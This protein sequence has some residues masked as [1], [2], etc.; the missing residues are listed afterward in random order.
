MSRRVPP[1]S[2]CRTSRPGTRRSISAT[3]SGSARRISFAETTVPEPG[4]CCI[5]SGRSPMTRT[6]RTSEPADSG[7]GGNGA[8]AGGRRRRVVGASELRHERE[9]ERDRHGEERR[10]CATPSH[11]AL[12][13]L[14]PL[15]P[16]EGG[17]HTVCAVQAML[18]C[19]PFALRMK[20]ELR[21]AIGVVHAGAKESERHRAAWPRGAAA[22]AAAA[23]CPARREAARR[24]GVV[25]RCPRAV[26]V[27]ERAFASAALITL[28]AIARA[29]A[30]IAFEQ[31]DV[32]GAGLQPAPSAPLE[33]GS[34]NAIA[35][36]KPR[37]DRTRITGR[38]FAQPLARDCYTLETEYA[39]TELKELTRKEFWA[40]PAARGLGPLWAACGPIETQRTACTLTRRTPGIDSR[41]SI[42]RPS[43]RF[44]GSFTSKVTSSRRL[45]SRRRS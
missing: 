39:E 10:Q 36:A 27:A 24:S 41:H 33:M 22:R 21:L 5:E 26:A 19:G 16:S 9:A 13:T 4:T 1:D 31:V 11:G 2:S 3:F 18:Q 8:A 7:A 6:S 17:G 37:M 35:A 38:M 12:H 14:I 30:V 23:A 45:S 44:R 20:A 40:A 43:S 15:Q 25:A 29:R 28:V 42:N 32:S 34:A